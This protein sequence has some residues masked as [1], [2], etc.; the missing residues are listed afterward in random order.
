MEGGETTGCMELE[1][2]P[3]WFSV[4]KQCTPVSR[5]TCSL[6]PQITPGHTEVH[7]CLTGGSS[8]DRK[9]S[10]SW[11]KW[12]RPLGQENRIRWIFLWK[13]KFSVFSLILCENKGGQD[14]SWCA[15]NATLCTVFVSFCVL[16]SLNQI[17]QTRQHIK[18]THPE[19]QRNHGNNR[20][21]ATKLKTPPACSEEELDSGCGAGRDSYPA[22]RKRHLYSYPRSV[23]FIVHPVHPSDIS[24][25]IT[26]DVLSQTSLPDHSTRYGLKSFS[27]IWEILFS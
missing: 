10:G 21:E 16:V 4:M 18:V 7:N 5:S 25:H 17:S 26:P 8:N 23:L 14:E 20:T 2:L 24:T 22:S 27:L 19:T 1:R 11:K 13:F 15:S 9:A 6:T 3:L 12:R